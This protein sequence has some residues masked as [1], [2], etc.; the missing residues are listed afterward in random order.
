[1]SNSDGTLDSFEPARFRPQLQLLLVAALAETRDEETKV[2]LEPSWRSASLLSSSA[3]W[4][5][6]LAAAASQRSGT[7]CWP[8]RA[9]SRKP[10]RACVC[11]RRGP[12]QRS[13]VPVELQ[14]AVDG[15]PEAPFFLQW[16]KVRWRRCTRGE[17]RAAVGQRLRAAVLF[18]G[19]RRWPILPSS[20]RHSPTCRPN[21]R[22]TLLKSAAFGRSCGSCL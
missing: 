22:C 3:W 1:V 17:Q 19:N 12:W 16:F 21:S 20:M 7:R 11:C 6:A 13:A 2:W 10:L 5:Q 15:D 8:C 14:T 9:A 4:W 18:E